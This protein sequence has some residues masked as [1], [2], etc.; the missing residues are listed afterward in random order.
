MTKK[1]SEDQPDPQPGA[2]PV[3]GSEASGSRWEPNA[4]TEQ[5]AA[6]DQARP[7]APAGESPPA[8]TPASYPPPVN[9]APGNA[10]FASLKALSSGAKGALVG[11]A[12][13]LVLGSGVTGFAIGQSGDDHERIDLRFGQT[14]FDRDGDRGGFPGGMPGHDGQLRQGGNGPFEGQLPPG[15]TTQDDSSPS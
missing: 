11:A 9:P 6:A 15:G 3:A 13:V 1:N 12:A 5:V 4:P 2:K 14:G 10:A 7:S 8:A